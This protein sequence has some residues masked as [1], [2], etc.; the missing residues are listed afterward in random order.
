MNL[1][2]IVVG[3]GPAGLSASIGLARAGFSVRVLEQRK[4]WQKRVCGSFLSA[5]ASQH[6]QWLGLLKSAREKGCFV[7]EAFLYQNDKLKATVPCQVKNFSG[8]AIPRK[9]LEEL[10]I[11]EAKKINVEIEWGMCVNKIQKISDSYWKVEAVS[12]SE[13]KKF[14]LESEVV[15][16]A[17]GRFS[18]FKKEVHET[19]GWFGWNAEFK[20][21]NPIPG[22][23]SL[24]FFPGGYFGT[25]TFKNGSSNVSGLIHSNFKKDFKGEWNE[26]LTHLIEC[27]SALKNKLR[28]ALE[29]STWKGVGPLPFGQ[30]VDL[31]PGIFAV[32]DAA[33]VCDPF[34]GEGIARALSSGSML[35][36]AFEKYKESM[37]AWKE[38]VRRWKKRYWVRQKI[39]SPLRAVIR[40]QTLTTAMLTLIR[41][42]NKIQKQLI[43]LLHS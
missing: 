25:L 22:E 20:T 26:F 5:E 40:N 14:V 36:H 27:Q 39:G 7:P 11:L 33:G 15:V 13:K 32:G 29:N 4:E 30:A 31:S 3:A 24:H 41:R 43:S 34:M 10:L 17:E 18:L 28:G 2:A 42:P 9:E 37:L 1:T 6:L 8:L 38:Y 23:L 19:T 21:L 12:T 35:Y 16:A